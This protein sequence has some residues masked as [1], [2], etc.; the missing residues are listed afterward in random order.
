MNEDHQDGFRAGNQ[1]DMLNGGESQQENDYNT[2]EN[3]Q[4]ERDQLLAF[5]E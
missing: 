5:K 1:S 4:M 2:F 3:L